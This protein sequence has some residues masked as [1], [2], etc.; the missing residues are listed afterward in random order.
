MKPS[1]A[2]LALC[3]IGSACLAQ[4]PQATELPG[5]PFSIRKT[6][7]I[8]GEG[9][10]DYLTLDPSA[11]QLLIAHGPVV[12]VVALDTGTVAG[13][14]TGLKDAHGVALDDEGLFGYVSDGPANDVKV[15]D[16]HSLDVVATAPT[17]RNPRAVVYEPASKLVFAICPDTQTQESKNPRRSST[18]QRVFDPLASSTVT[19]IDAVSHKRLADMILPGKLG[20]AQADGRGTVYVNITDRNQIGYF[21]AQGIEARLRELAGAAPLDGTK[22]AKAAAGDSTPT[23][24]WRD[25]VHDPQPISNRLH[26]FS[27]GMNCMS[28][29]GLAVDG[30]N[31]RLFVACDNNKMEILDATNG[32]PVT[33]LPIGAGTDAIGYDPNHGLIYAANG[34]GVGSL[35]IIRQHLNDSYAVIQDLPTQARA[36]T[37]AV[38]PETGEVYLVTNIT[39]F[40]LSK[41]GTVNAPGELPV[42]QATPVLGSFEVLVVGNGDH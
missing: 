31:Q 41:K 8:G 42:I 6:W 22:T 20:F 9:N 4:V 38:N 34:A 25:T 2:I 30:T 26:A 1:L 14:V 37:L 24:D 32:Q 35:T 28:P 33:T 19:V 40:D 10:W 18:G 23:I 39:G 29:K 7:M 15:F 17:G 12:Q 16:R 3:L 5:K 27:L 21:N 13:E 11:L 36:R